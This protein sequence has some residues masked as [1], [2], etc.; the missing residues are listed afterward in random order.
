[1][2]PASA[3]IG[4]VHLTVGDL[5][6]VGEFYRDTLGFR[7]THRVDER[8]VFLSATGSYPYHIGLRADPLARPPDRRTAGLY[9]T[10][11][12]LPTRADLGRLLAHLLQVGWPIQGA[13]DHGVSEAVYLADPEGNG[14][15]IY[16]D[17]PRERWTFVR[18]GLVMPTKPMDVDA[19]LAEGTGGWDGLPAATSIGHVHLRVGDLS[20]AE[21]FYSGVIGFEV[22]ARTYP[23]ALFFAAGGYHHHLGTNIWA[24]T[25]LTP[26][27]VEIRGLRYFTI[28]LPDRAAL[29][30]A[31]ERI[32]RA[33]LTP[34]AV[35]GGDAPAI[36]VRDPDG[37]TVVLTVDQGA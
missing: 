18:G 35:E 15:E 16:A 26:A 13:S 23:G 29:A 21:A 36:S 14:I 3:S 8:T 17:R 6:H 27:S 34:E 2:L 33:E 7:E 32:H 10:A 5:G 11:I 28:R 22:T 30:A 31:D 37:I 4:L 19:V 24:G 25:N 1:M 20:R 9:H 12:L